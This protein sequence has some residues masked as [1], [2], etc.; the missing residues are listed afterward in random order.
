MGAIVVGIWAKLRRMC[1]DGC[2]SRK[3][4]RFIVGHAAAAAAGTTLG[5][6][7][8]ARAALGIRGDCV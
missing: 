5:L 3:R 1:C 7:T 6:L 2:R 4:E 8:L